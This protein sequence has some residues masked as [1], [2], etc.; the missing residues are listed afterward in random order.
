MPLS[1]KVSLITAARNAERYIVQTI[2]SVRAQTFQDWEYIIAE[3]GST[4]GT[5]A[6]I[7]RF[8]DDERIRLISVARKGKAV[9]RNAAF[10]ESRGRYI[11]NID[12]D[13]LWEREKLAKQ[14]KVFERRPDIALVYTG[15]KFLNEITH[16]EKIRIPFD[17]SKSA[18]PLKH[19]LTIDNPITHSSVLFRKDLFF[20]GRYQYEELEKVD[21]LITYWRVLAACNKAGFIPEPLTVYRIHAESEHENQPVDEFCE[22]YRKSLNTFFAL[23]NLPRRVVNLKRH[24]VATMYFISGTVGL[25]RRGSLM[26]SAKYLLKS[27]C[28]HPAIAY[29]CLYPLL[30]CLARPI[31]LH[32]SRLAAC[33]SRLRGEAPQNN[34]RSD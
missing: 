32:N 8:L 5:V 27:I 2:E 21:E 10:A 23:P 28:L 11:A 17:L 22:W 6:A 25:P 29:R 24:A 20:D 34:L 15:V 4:D 1:P 33:M 13:D 26:I 9:G 7:R 16:T 18:D 3:H 14:L 30:G 12:A 31:L 19:M